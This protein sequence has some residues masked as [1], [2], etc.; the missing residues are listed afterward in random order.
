M[1][2]KSEQINPASANVCLLHFGALVP[3]S[4]PPSGQL[5]GTE[6]KYRERHKKVSEVWQRFGL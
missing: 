4:L 1:L 6:A 3:I 5:V 2:W